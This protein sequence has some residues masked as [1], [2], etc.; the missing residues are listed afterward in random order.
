MPWIAIPKAR[1]RANAVERWRAAYRER[2]VGWSAGAVA[3]VL[4]LGFWFAVAHKLA[5]GGS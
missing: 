5:S 4:A 3:L 1:R 2:L